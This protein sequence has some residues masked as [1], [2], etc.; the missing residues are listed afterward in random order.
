MQV[1]FQI[2]ASAD[3]PAIAIAVGATAARRSVTRWVGSDVADMLMAGTPTLVLSGTFPHWRVPV[4]LGSSRGVV[5]E[6]GI[7]DVH[8][9]T[10]ALSTSPELI[11]RLRQQAVT[12]VAANQDGS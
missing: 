12:L 7:V 3:A 5:G 4:V 8:A 11:E 6:V 9:H 1:E 2:E 10:G